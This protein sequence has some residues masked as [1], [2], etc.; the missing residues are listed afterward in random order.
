MYIHTSVFVLFETSTTVQYSTWCQNRG[1]ICISST[2]RTYRSNP[3]VFCIHS[4]ILIILQIL[5]DRI[6]YKEE[7]REDIQGEIPGSSQSLKTVFFTVFPLLPHA[8]QGKDRIFILFQEDSSNSTRNTTT[9]RLILCRQ[10]QGILQQLFPM[11][12]S[13]PHGRI[14][15][16]APYSTPRLLVILPAETGF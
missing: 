16:Q 3:A 2:R 10:I 9:T 7:E 11:H 8:I 5:Q 6:F 12:P 4:S 1:C 13:I 14:R 15:L